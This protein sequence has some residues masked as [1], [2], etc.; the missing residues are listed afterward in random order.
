MIDV[1]DHVFQCRLDVVAGNRR[2]EKRALQIVQPRRSVGLEQIHYLL[3]QH[4]V[5]NR[6]QVPLRSRELEL[7][8]PVDAIERPLA[9]SRNEQMSD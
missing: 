3:V 7:P 6:L 9:N 8:L 4:L 1:D 2:A 5:E